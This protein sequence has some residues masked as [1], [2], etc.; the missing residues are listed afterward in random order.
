MNGNPIKRTTLILGAL[1][2]VAVASAQAQDTKPFI[3]AWK[4]TLSVAGV[5]LE[6]GLP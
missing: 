3:G 1:A 4:G 5:E 2:F 6:I